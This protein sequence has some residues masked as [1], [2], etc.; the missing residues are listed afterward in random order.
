ML[1]TIIL[2]VSVSGLNSVWNEVLFSR[3]LLYHCNSIYIFK[4]FN[5]ISYNKVYLA[6]YLLS[7]FIATIYSDYNL[8]W[9]LVVY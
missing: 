9:W 2:T 8:V 3:F 5:F 6:D 7:H 1:T 4:I